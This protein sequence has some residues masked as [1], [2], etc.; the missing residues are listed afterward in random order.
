MVVNILYPS[1]YRSIYLYTHTY[2][3]LCVCD[4]WLQG[5]FGVSELSS[6]AGFQVA[7]KT[8]LKNTE[9]LVDKACSCAPGVETIRAF[10]Q[11]SD[12]LCKVADLV[13]STPKGVA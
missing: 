6:P 8:A 3:Y 12:G 7:S 13:S 10:D 9:L 2:T 11:L 5:L 4:L 1:I